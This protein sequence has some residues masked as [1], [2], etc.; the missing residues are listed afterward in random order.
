M[1]TINN[2]NEKHFR[3][4]CLGL[5]LSSYGPAVIACLASTQNVSRKHRRPKL[6]IRG[7]SDQIVMVYVRVSS[8]D[9]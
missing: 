8:V 4:K 2:K 1:M 5:S 9:V 3:G 7:I 6:T